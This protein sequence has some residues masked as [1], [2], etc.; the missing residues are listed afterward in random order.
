MTIFVGS[1]RFT[2][3][4][5]ESPN[6]KPKEIGRILARNSLSSRSV[7][8]IHSP[9]VRNSCASW[10]PIDT[11]GTIGTPALSAART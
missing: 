6:G 8:A 11:D 5:A 4:T 7:L 2:G 3:S 10:P 9:R 1:G